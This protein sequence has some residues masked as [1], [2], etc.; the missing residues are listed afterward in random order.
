MYS[1]EFLNILKYSFNRQTDG[2]ILAKEIQELKENAGGGGLE[3]SQYVFVAADG[4]PTE[5]AAELQAAYDKAK[6]MSPSATNKITIIAAPGEYAFPSTF[7]MDTEYINLVSLTG[8]RDVI[9]DLEGLVDP[10]PLDNNFNIIT[11]EKCL[12]INADNVY[13]KGIEG[14]YYDSQSWFNWWGGSTDYN[15]PIDIGDNLSNILVENCKGGSFSFGYEKIT[16][17]TFINCEANVYSFGSFDGTASGTFINCVAGMES[18]GGGQN[19]IASGTFVNCVAASLSFGSRT[20][21][22]GTFTNCVG[23]NV[24]F[25]G[26]ALATLTGKLYYCRLTNGTF[27]T[28]SGGGRVYYSVDGN[29]N[30]NNQ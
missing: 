10:L 4:T 23:G 2:K 15:L 18:F 1:R 3:G 21:A 30:P 17:G 16:S 19:G 8:N 9:F 6:T 11:I 5:N 27:K 20:L 28:V 14:K 24:S 29:G 12:L 25:G 7:V 22:S 26:T 13:V